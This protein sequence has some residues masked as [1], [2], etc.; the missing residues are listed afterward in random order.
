MAVICDQSADRLWLMMFKP[1][2]DVRHQ[3][4]VP[5]LDRLAVFRGAIMKMSMSA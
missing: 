3:E 2:G 1:F 4:F 5:V